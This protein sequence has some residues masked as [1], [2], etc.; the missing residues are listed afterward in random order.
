MGSY[1]TKVER[2]TVHPELGR[3][4]PGETRDGDNLD[5]RYPGLFTKPRTKKAAKKKSPKKTSK[6]ASDASDGATS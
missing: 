2:P 3:L 6:A 5:K 1:K 4:E